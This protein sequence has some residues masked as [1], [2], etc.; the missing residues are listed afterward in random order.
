LREGWAGPEVDKVWTD[1]PHARLIVPLEGRAQTNAPVDVRIT[2][3]LCRPDVSRRKG[4]T[5]IV[6]AQGRDTGD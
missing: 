5:I 1:G 6:N 3:G 2:F 4:I